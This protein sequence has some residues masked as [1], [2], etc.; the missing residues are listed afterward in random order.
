MHLWES[1]TVVY[2]SLAIAASSILIS[3]YHTYVFLR[4]MLPNMNITNDKE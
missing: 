3:S 1:L 2:T 4:N